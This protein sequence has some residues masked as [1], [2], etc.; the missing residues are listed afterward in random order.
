MAQAAEELARILAAGIQD[1]PKPA[2][3]IEPFDLGAPW[4]H[5]ANEAELGELSK[6]HMRITRKQQALTDLI[7]ER[8]IIRRRCI[9][10]MRRNDGKP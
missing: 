9:Q 2:N 6:L 7:E 10:R 8:A 1:L 3:L 5:H 4:T